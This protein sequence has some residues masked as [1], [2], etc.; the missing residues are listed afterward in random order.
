MPVTT[1]DLTARLEVDGAASDRTAGVINTMR[2][3]AA[4]DAAIHNARVLFVAWG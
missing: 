1:L 3:A 2:T 4:V